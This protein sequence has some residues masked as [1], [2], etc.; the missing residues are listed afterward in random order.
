MDERLLERFD[1]YLEKKGYANRSEAIRD[2][3]RD[4]LVE[5][6]WGHPREKVAATVTLIY[7][8]HA[9]DLAERLTELQ[10]HHGDVVVATTHVH[11]DNDNCLEVVILRGKCKPVRTLADQLIAS[12]ASSTAKRFSPR[13]GGTCGV[14]GSTHSFLKRGVA[15]RPGELENFCSYFSLSDHP[16]RFWSKSQQPF[17]FLPRSKRS[18]ARLRRHDLFPDTIR[19]T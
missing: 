10:H 11:L 2:L 1:K 14:R 8:H 5:E 16:A 9:S 17:A 18:S 13:K 7:N 12:R 3:I 19:E 6:Q 4:A 15:A